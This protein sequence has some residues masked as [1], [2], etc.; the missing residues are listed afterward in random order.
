MFHL[1]VWITVKADVNIETVSKLLA[2]QVPLTRAEPGCVRFEV[3]HSQADPRRFL[4]VE[5]WNEKA[6]WEAHRLAKAFTEIYT[7]QVLP[8]VDREP[9]ASAL[10]E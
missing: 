2:S 10:I 6:D 5:W 4:L 8:L 9:H 3:Y 7:P 1:N